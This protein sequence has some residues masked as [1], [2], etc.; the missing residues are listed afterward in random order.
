MVKLIP[1]EIREA[2]FPEARFLSEDEQAIYEDVIKSFSGKAY[3]SLNIRQNGSNIF[4]V[5][6]LNQI[7]IQT[8]TMSQ[9]EDALENGLPLQGQYEDAPALVLRS[10]I[11]SHAQNN[12][13]AQSLAKIISPNFNHAVVLNGLEIKSDTD[14]KY[15]LSFI[16]GAKFE[17]FEA[18]E[19]DHTNNGK[20]FSHLDQ[21]G[22]PIFDKEGNRT[23]YTRDSGLSRVYLGGVLVAD[24]S[25]EHLASSNDFGRVVV[26]DNAE[27]AQKI[28][29]EEIKVEAYTPTQISQTF[30]ELK[31]S[32]LELLL[33]HLKNT[34]KK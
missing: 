2:V 28:S 26:I 13:L 7:G 5:L 14:S 21:R 23:L 10:A 9:L 18:P 16:P 25:D 17:Y 34:I 20:K 4:K 3:D 11:D 1:K 15:G 29:A 19:L 12:Y 24:A 31:L 32:V 6:Y 27:G 22:M 30:S 33:K 8:A